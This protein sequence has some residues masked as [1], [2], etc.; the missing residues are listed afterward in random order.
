MSGSVVSIITPCYRQAKFLSGAIR[1]VRAQS[2]RHIEM[3]I[4]NDGSDDDTDAVVAEAGSD[5][6]YIKQVNAGLPAARNAGIAAASGQYFLF[7][8]SDDLLHP[9]AVAWHVEGMEGRQSRLTVTGYRYFENDPEK[10]EDTLLPRNE[11]ALPRLFHFNLAPPHGYMCSRAMIESVGLF[12]P[13]L[14]SCED[15]H[16]WLRLALFGCE[17]KTISRIGAYYRKHPGQMSSNHDRMSRCRI[18]VLSLVS[19]LIAQD[20]NI[21]ENWGSY[22][23]QLRQMRAEM[24]FELGYWHAKRGNP[25][26]AMA[27]Y[28]EALKCG[29]KPATCAAAMGKAFGHA[30]VSRVGSSAR[31]RVA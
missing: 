25:V 30:V 14:R 23:E 19:N 15:W 24:N 13:Q 18:Q 17:L 8:D 28:A 27:L 4:V 9:D 29:Y 6:V 22:L 7:L 20:K 21:R 3:V 11:P 12:D 26:K 31:P 10:G 2:Y 5:V 1:C 16:F